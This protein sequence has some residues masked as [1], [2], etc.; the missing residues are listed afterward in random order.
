MTMTLKTMF[1]TVSLGALAA[2]SED[3]GGFYT[4]SGKFLDEGGFGN[5]TMSNFQA[6]TGE[7]DFAQR[8]TMKFGGDVPPT[9]NFAFN[10][11]D[12]DSDAKSVLDRQASWM[13]QFP[14]ARFRVFGHTD[15]VGSETYN[16]SL[17]MRRA[18]A[19]VDY[20]VSQ[21]ISK[22]RV[23]AVISEGETMPIV[24][25]EDRERRNR[26]AITEVAGL[27]NGFGGLGLNGKYAAVI[28]REYV[29]SAVPIPAGFKQETTGG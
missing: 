12:L 21:G 1:V 8:M 28:W 19:V 17:G 20:L 11:A 16:Q 27:A 26:R 25:T 15:L 5:P 18:T 9:V 6:Q 24:Q 14:E 10:Q 4:E 29:N 22:D 23:E 13:K 2:C 3:L 7:A